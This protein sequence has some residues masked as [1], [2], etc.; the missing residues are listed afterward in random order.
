MLQPDM[1]EK[2]SQDL[3][4]IFHDAGQFYWGKPESWLENRVLF[5]SQSIPFVLPH[6]Q[7]QDID[8]MDDWR[9]AE[10]IMRLLDSDL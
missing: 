6:Y 4:D 3:E 1:F 2:R 10:Y 8:T 5:S 9:R 7:V